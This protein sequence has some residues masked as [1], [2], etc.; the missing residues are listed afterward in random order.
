[1]TIQIQA[2]VDDGLLDLGKIFSSAKW[3]TQEIVATYIVC[4]FGNDGCQPGEQEV[5]IESA[6]EYGIVAYRWYESESGDH[7]AILLDRDDAIAAG[8]EHASDSDETP[9]LDGQ[10]EQILATGYFGDSADADDIRSICEAL[11]GHSQGV[12]LLP[13]GEMPAQPIGRLWTTNGYLQCEHVQ[14]SAT[15]GTVELAASSL[16][17]ACA[18]AE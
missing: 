15:H 4:C 7:G 8:E 12:I 2:L 16:L 3:D 11:C 6:T 10:I 5:R 14:M 9:D 13:R 1:M 17:A 18:S